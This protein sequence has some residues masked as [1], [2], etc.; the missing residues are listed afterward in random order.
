MVFCCVPLCNSNSWNSDSSVTFHEFP[1]NP[2]LAAKWIQQINHAMTAR[3]KPMWFPAGKSGKPM[4]CSRHFLDIDF[5][6]DSDKLKPRV[7]PTVFGRKYIG[8]GT[9]EAAIKSPT[10]VKSPWIVNLVK[11]SND[12]APSTSKV[13]SPVIKVE[14]ANSKTVHTV[15]SCSEDDDP[16]E[17]SL[18]SDDHQ[19]FR[20]E[21]TQPTQTVFKPIERNFHF[22]SRFRFGHRF[23]S[24]RPQKKYIKPD[25]NSYIV[26][27]ASAAM[28]KISLANAGGMVQ[29]HKKQKNS[30][31]ELIEIGP[32][33]FLKINPEVIKVNKKLS[34]SGNTVLQFVMDQKLANSQ[35][36][37][38]LL[39]KLVH[40]W[41]AVNSPPKDSEAPKPNDFQDK[42][43]EPEKV[44]CSTND[45]EPVVQHVLGHLVETH[46]CKDSGLCLKETKDIDKNV[47]SH[48]DDASP[49]PGTT[50]LST[51][52]TAETEETAETT[53]K[54]KTSQNILNK[55][56]VLFTTNLPLSHCMM[57]KPKFLTQLKQKS[58]QISQLKFKIAALTKKVEELED[59]CVVQERQLSYSFIKRLKTIRKNANKGDSCAT[60]ILEQIRC[61][62]GKNKMRWSDSTLSQCAVW[63]R[64]APYAYEYF[65]KADFF[66]LPCLGT[67]KR[68]MKKHP[69][70]KFLNRANGSHTNEDESSSDFDFDD[71]DSGKEG[72]GNSDANE[73]ADASTISSTVINELTQPANFPTNTTEAHT[74]TVIDQTPT[75]EKPTD[76]ATFPMTV[77][78]TS[79][80]VQELILPS[81]EVVQCYSS[82]I[83]NSTDASNQYYIIP[84]VDQTSV[85]DHEYNVI[86]ASD[87]IILQNLENAQLPLQQEQL[88]FIT[89]SGDQLECTETEIVTASMS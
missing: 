26:D 41:T 61:Y 77:D 63:C 65:K 27:K 64:K 12:S 79:L 59:R 86:Q 2:D 85:G 9:N 40:G 89:N 78:G 18:E 81:G 57:D 3:Q 35:A 17:V 22:Q 67:V 7:V 73:T 14:N 30:K 11:P 28:P 56:P 49:T 48:I 80:E 72:Q 87:S 33:T 70:L 39:P 46:V 6:E 24:N 25:V 31:N 53:G 52:A 15:P 13:Q 43:Q 50:V 68:F 44:T 54:S 88:I 36:A 55:A 76:L 42:K 74:T 34:P 32:N 23:G 60:Y 1:S 62:A 75:L 58:R 45:K 10:K 20:Q 38:D 19:S 21:L 82:S 37:A 47:D 84:N 29:K 16:D 4:I 51:S 69:E 5:R 8:V 66:K 83:C 71:S